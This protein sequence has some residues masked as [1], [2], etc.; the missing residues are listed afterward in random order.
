[1][2][3]AWDSQLIQELQR[4]QVKIQLAFIICHGLDG[5]WKTIHW[6]YTNLENG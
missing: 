2:N 3:K 4:T 5:P 1:M 6:K